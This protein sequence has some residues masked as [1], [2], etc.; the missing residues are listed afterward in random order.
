VVRRCGGERIVAEGSGFCDTMHAFRKFGYD[1]IAE[2]H[3]AE[4]VDL[5]TDE[6]EIVEGDALALKRF[7][8]PTTL[9]NSFIISAAVLKLH[10]IT[11]VTLSLKNMLGATIGS[12]GR[13]HRFGIEESIVDINGYERPGLALID[14]IYGNMDGELGRRPKRF[15]VLIAS[16]DL[17]AADCVGCGILGVDP[18]SVRHILLA[19]RRGLGSTTFELIEEKI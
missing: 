12:K 8:F 15:N 11:K 2:E 14:G 6:Y 5:N 19:E 13:F 3:G 16:T 10:S 1:R 17:V 4:L 9:K 7:E 18:K